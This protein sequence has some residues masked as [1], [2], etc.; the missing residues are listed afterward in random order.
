MRLF[1]Q[2]VSIFTHRLY[3]APKKICYPAIANIIIKKIKII[4]ASRSKGNELTNDPI[5]IFNP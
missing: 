4:I 5:S 3:N 1:N 2:P